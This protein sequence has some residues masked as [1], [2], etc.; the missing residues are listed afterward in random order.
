MSKSFNPRFLSM[1][2]ET[3]LWHTI[4]D[5]KSAFNPRFLSMT[6]ETSAIKSHLRLNQR[7]FNPRFLSMTFET[8]LLICYIQFM[9]YFQSSFFEYD[10]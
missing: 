7:S 6:F 9:I 1:T 10:L 4:N 5:T 2:F 8:F 3:S